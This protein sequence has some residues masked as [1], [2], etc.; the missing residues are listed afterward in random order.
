LPRDAGDA[1]GEAITIQ[2]EPD[3][4]GDFH[5]AA[6]RQLRHEKGKRSAAGC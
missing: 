3:L 4:G 6:R 5:P 2:E 1:L